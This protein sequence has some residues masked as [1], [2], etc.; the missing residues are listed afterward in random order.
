[1]PLHPKSLVQISDGRFTF[2]PLLMKNMI[3]DGP[4]GLTLQVHPLLL[5]LH[6]KCPCAH[7]RLRSGLKRFIRLQ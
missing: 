5:I 1:M 7:E 4:P 2:R 6:A 3:T